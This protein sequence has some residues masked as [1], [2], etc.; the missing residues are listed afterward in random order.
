M[1][2]P[3]KPFIIQLRELFRSRPRHLGGCLNTKHSHTEYGPIQ[4][5]QPRVSSDRG[6]I[7]FWISLY[8]VIST[9]IPRYMNSRVALY[10][11]QCLE[12]SESFLF[13]L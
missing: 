1:T 3:T 5:A 9:S 6:P 2:C 11:N 4:I 10:S 13:T 8:S 7:T 12:F